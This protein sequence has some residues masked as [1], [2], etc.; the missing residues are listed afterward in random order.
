MSFP[1]TKK[2]VWI[3]GASSGIGEHL[4]YRI[5]RDQPY[6]V[7]SGRRTEALEFVAA[8]T[9]LPEGHILIL[10]LDLSKPETFAEAAKKVIECYG[11]IDYLV[12]NSGIGHKSGVLETSDAVDRKVMEVNF[13]GN[14]RLTK[15]VLPYML[16]Q[17]A[18]QIT[19]ISSMLSKFGAPDVAT[20]AASK[21]AL[22]GWYESLRV[23]LYDQN[24]AIQVIAPGFIK[25][26]VTVK[27]LD[28]E[29]K[30]YG[31]NSPAQ[32]K[33]MDPKKC[34]IKIKKIMKSKKPFA[35][36][37]GWELGSIPFKTI[38]PRMFFWAMRALSRNS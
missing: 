37:G 36:V 33:G 14:I 18:G 32:E 21:H 3:T 4:A 35:Y 10:P 16:E 24:I 30:P 6:L 8:Q 9:N 25:T 26:D 27:S 1:F 28:G 13:F 5:A 19:V 22:N 7:L 34:A 38:A 29:G 20:Y 2:V 12:N 23:E 11:R 15:T 17:G 31:Q